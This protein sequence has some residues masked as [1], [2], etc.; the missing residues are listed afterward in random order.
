MIFNEEAP[1]DQAVVANP[2]EAIPYIN[3]TP[4]EHNEYVTA[5]VMIPIGEDRMKVVVKQ[6]IKNDNGLPVG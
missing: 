3:C 1:E 6:R 2:L 5:E 4:E